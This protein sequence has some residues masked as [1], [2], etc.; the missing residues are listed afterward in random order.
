MLNV[1]ILPHPYPSYHPQ[2]K[3]KCCPTQLNPPPAADPPGARPGWHCARR[4]FLFSS[5]PPARNISEGVLHWAGRRFG[6]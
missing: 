1:L 6:L 4:W 2:E 5:R 3:L